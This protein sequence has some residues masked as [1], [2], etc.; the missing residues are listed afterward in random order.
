MS[1]EQVTASKEQIDSQLREANI[2][3]FT[4]TMA[5]H[6]EAA[7]GS[8]PEHLYA[9]SSAAG[10]DHDNMDASL[11]MSPDYVQP[12]IPTDL[13]ILVERL[14]SQDGA[15]WLR[16]SAARK[17]I[18]WRKA[19]GGPRP[20]DLYRPL[21][22]D[23]SYAQA[24]LPSSGRV[25][26]PPVGPTSSFAIARVADHTQREE[27]LAQLRLANWAADLQKSLDNERAHYEQLA[28]GERAVWLTERL[29]ECV[30]DGTLVA[31]SGPGRTTSPSPSSTSSSSLRTDGKTR[32]K[33]G[34]AGRVKPTPHQDPLGLLGVASDLRRKGLVV[35]EVVGSI[36][37][38]GGVVIW[39]SKHYGQF[40]PYE[41]MISEWDKFWYGGR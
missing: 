11:L 25:L 7:S 6:N 15:S 21:G 27:R 14:F 40:Q 5:S 2:R 13:A 38:I 30:Q 35:L 16:H 37:V 10:S 41:W 24:P 29:G 23:S 33:L 36:S 8:F 17:Y 28:R 32:R 20:M 9:I 12:L 4:F 18:Q 39:V 3:P 31:V 1:P 34:L 22:M 19:E 26:T